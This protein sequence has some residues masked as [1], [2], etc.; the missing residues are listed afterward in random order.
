MKSA[1]EIGSQH[2]GERLLKGQEQHDLNRVNKTMFELGIFLLRER[3]TL[4]RDLGVFKYSFLDH[5]VQLVEPHVRVELHSGAN[6]DKARAISMRINGVEG[7]FR[8]TKK[9]RKG[10]DSY[11]CERI[12]RRPGVGFVKATMG[13]EMSQKFL[14]SMEQLAKDI[15]LQSQN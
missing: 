8:V 2:I 10:Q 9:S 13:L 14:T 15:G 1:I 11:M 12:V 7:I 4:K 5:T 6:L 3:G